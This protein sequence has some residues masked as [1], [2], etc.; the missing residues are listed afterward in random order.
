MTTVTAREAAEIAAANA[1]DRPS[2]VFVHGLW[3]LAS[4]WDGWRAW[5]EERGYSTVA[6][7]WPGDPLTVAGARQDSSALRR[8]SVA[9]LANH[10]GEVAT[11][12]KREPI[13]IGH[14]FG[15]LLVQIAAGRGLASATVAIDPAPSKGVLPMPFS[16][17][18]ASFPVLRN[19]ANRARTVTLSF[20]QFR[21]GFANTLD[22]PEARGLYESLHVPGPGRP[23]FQVAA[24][25]V[26]PG[27]ATFA[28]KRNPHRGPMLLITGENDNIV[29]MAMTRAAYRKQ[30]RNA[31]VTEIRQIPDAGHSLVVDHHWTTVAEASYEFLRG[32]IR[33]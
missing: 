5:F 1:A 13:L 30:R 16:A 3:L 6:A 26:L 33:E 25:N 2:I 9:D 23:L 12:L 28:D 18:R 22:E 21:Y 17:L 20:E 8:T 7:D 14:S 29:P 27:R 19:P 24:A 32:C 10:L 4:S 11:A 15:G 31:A